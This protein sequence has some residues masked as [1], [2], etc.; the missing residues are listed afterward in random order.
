VLK[1]DNIQSGRIEEDFLSVIQAVAGD[2]DLN[3]RSTL[4]AMRQQI[5]D[6]RRNGLGR[7]SERRE[8][9]ASDTAE[10]FWRCGGDCPNLSGNCRVRGTHAGRQLGGR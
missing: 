2:Y 3:L 1:G 4:A 7:P 10:P 6:F 8:S 5:R 9:Q